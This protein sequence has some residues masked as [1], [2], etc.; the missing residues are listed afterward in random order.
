MLGMDKRGIYWLP[1][2]E[3]PAAYYFGNR[4]NEDAIVRHTSTQ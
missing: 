3:P 1:Y 4:A 2:H